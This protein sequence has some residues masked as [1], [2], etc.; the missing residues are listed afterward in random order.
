MKRWPF[1]L[2]LAVLI[3]GVASSSIH[4]IPRIAEARMPMVVMSGSTAAEAPE[5][6]ISYDSYEY[7]V[8]TGSN[9]VVSVPANT[10]D[11]DL[12]VVI[13]NNDDASAINPSGWTQ[14]VTGQYTSAILYVGYR[15][16]SSEPASYDFGSDTQ[17]AGII[18]LLTKTSGTWS[19]DDSAID[20]TSVGA[21]PE[22]GAVTMG[23]GGGMLLFAWGGDDSTTVVTPPADMTQVYIGSPGSSHVGGWYES[24]DA[25]DHTKTI[26]LSGGNNAAAAI[27]VGLD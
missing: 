8:N 23:S 6:S 9:C 17:L 21:T 14:I 19:V 13:L 4:N 18:I 5:Q 24:V 25:G 10:E 22:P 20:Y 1:L 26:T 11:G 15:T 7:G 27:A 16:A 12:L 3:S 2:I